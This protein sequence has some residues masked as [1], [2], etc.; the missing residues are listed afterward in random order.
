M[1]R[2]W[3]GSLALHN[4]NHKYPRK[5]RYSLQEDRRAWRISCDNVRS[6]GISAEVYCLTVVSS[7]DKCEPAGRPRHRFPPC[8]HPLPRSIPE[9]TKN[10]AFLLTVRGMRCFLLRNQQWLSSP[11]SLFS[12]SLLL[13]LCCRRRLLLRGCLLLRGSRLLRALCCTGKGGHRSGRHRLNVGSIVLA[14]RL[15]EEARC[16]AEHNQESSQSPC[17]FL[18]KICRLAYAE[19][20]IGTGNV[21]SQTAAFGFLDEN[22]NGQQDSR[23]HGEDN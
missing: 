20:R 22:H 3:L 13:T 7:Q 9:Q 18:H 19:H 12:R 10:T 15:H 6:S 5:R 8:Q 1:H 16:H 4:E 23:N 17:G 21:R 14:Y 11:S 2:T